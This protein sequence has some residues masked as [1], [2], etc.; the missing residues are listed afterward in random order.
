MASREI[1]SIN[2]AIEAEAI[3]IAGEYYEEDHSVTFELCH[4][5]ATQLDEG[6][7]LGAG[8]DDV[9]EYADS[10]LEDATAVAAVAAADALPLPSEVV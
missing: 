1:R 3:A 2:Q 8:I 6:E 5:I 10:L 7:V 4:C 9:L